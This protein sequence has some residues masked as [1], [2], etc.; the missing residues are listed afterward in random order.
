M[1]CSDAV[2]SRMM[3]T[4]MVGRRVREFLWQLGLVRSCPAC[5]GVLRKHGY[6]YEGAFYYTCSVCDWGHQQ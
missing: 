1:V 5:R 2:K 4:G 3:M 6:T